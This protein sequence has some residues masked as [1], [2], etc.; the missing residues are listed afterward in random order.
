MLCLKRGSM[1]TFMLCLIVFCGFGLALGIPQYKKYKNISKGRRA[2]E[3]GSALA[4]AEASYKTAHGAYTAQWESLALPEE[5]AACTREDEKNALVCGEYRFTLNGNVLRAEHVRFPKW[6]DFYLDE[7]YVDCSH[8][9]DSDAGRRI[10]SGINE[11]F[12]V[13]I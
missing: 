4:F 11:S 9:E 5:A 10:C 7:G 1:H 2:L 12:P 3:L 6:L 8:A 13:K